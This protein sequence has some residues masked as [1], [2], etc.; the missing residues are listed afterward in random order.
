M[1]PI[2]RTARLE[3]VPATVEM[4]VADLHRRE[5]LPR[6]L[7]AELGEGWPPPLYD[8]RAMY[9]VKRSLEADPALGVWTTWY[10]ILKRPRIVI[11]LSGFKGRPV[12]GCVELGYTVLERYQRRGFATEAVTVMTQWALANGANCVM[13]E[14][15]P[16]LAASCRVLARCGFAFVGDGSEPGVL[17]FAR[18]RHIPLPSESR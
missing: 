13:A 18:E 3:L 12:K 5:R 8:T 15:L 1:K 6:L 9:S 2:V 17:R 11:G 14:T 7:R 4:A 10:W 16:E